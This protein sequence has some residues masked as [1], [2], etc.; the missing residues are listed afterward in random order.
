MIGFPWG[1][2]SLGPIRIEV[3]SEPTSCFQ[4]GAVFRE[5]TVCW[6]DPSND[7]F[8]SWTNDA[9]LL[10][11]YLVQDLLLLKMKIKT[12]LTILYIFTH[13]PV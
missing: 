11:I 9:H 13:A 7:I 10:V 2:Y 3:G 8:Y 5:R 4:K 12:A 6:T 1:R